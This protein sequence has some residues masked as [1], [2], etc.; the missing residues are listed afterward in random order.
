MN[1]SKLTIL[2][3]IL[4]GQSLIRSEMPPQAKKRK[5][6]SDTAKWTDHQIQM[7][8]TMWKEPDVLEAIQQP[9]PVYVL[10]ANRL[11]DVWGN[12]ECPD[13]HIWD[14]HMV[15]DKIKHLRNQ[16]LEIQEELQKQQQQQEEEKQQE[17]QESEDVAILTSWPYYGDLHEIISAVPTKPKPQ[18]KVSNCV[19]CLYQVMLSMCALYKGSERLGL[20]QA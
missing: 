4:S 14:P 9:K 20:F 1:T 8:I 10:L 2:E 5:L 12:I 17:Q 13:R 11:N 6:S 16:Y 18:G 19:Y 3:S 15:K 7:L